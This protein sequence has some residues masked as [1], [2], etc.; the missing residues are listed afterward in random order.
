MKLVIIR[1]PE[2]NKD[3]GSAGEPSAPS[4]KGKE[5]LAR[6]AET[7]RDQGVQ[8]V[9]HSIMPRAAIAANELA[10]TLRVPSIDQEGLEERSFGDWNSWEWP[11]IAQ[12]LDKL[13]PEERYTFVPPNGESWQQ[14]TE[15]LGV[16]LVHIA[17]L[18]Y[19]S[20]AVMMHTGSMR[21]LLP[22]VRGEPRE[23][24]LQ[25]MPDYGEAVVEE[26]VAQG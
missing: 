15:R 16:A 24:T 18:E 5:Q 20:V 14:M 6:V 8:A 23:S 10:Q 9:I 4:F 26:Y 19:E 7:C 11:Q 2:I 3:A 1:R 12:E 25:F 17:S 13:T 22:I 21:G